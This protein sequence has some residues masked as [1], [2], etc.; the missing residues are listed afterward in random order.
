MSGELHL[1]L[2]SSTSDCNITQLNQTQQ[3]NILLA[4]GITAL[5]SVVSCIIGV[6]MVIALRLY[7]HFIYRLASYQVLGSLF[8]GTA[9]ALVLV[10]IDYDEEK[11]QYRV[12]C[13]ITAFLIEYSLWVKLIFTIWLTFHLFAYVVFYKNLK[14]L[15]YLYLFSPM[16]FPLLFVWIPFIDGS[17]GVSGAWCYIRSW[18]DNCATNKYDP[19]I[20]EQFVL[21][22]GP[23]TAALIVNIIIIIFMIVI[24][25]RRVRVDLDV[26]IQHS[27]ST[28]L[29]STAL[30]NKKVEVLKQLVPLLAYP[31]IYFTLLIFPLTNRIYMAKANSLDPPLI[32][33]QA[34]AQSSMGFFAGLALIL[35]IT[36]IQIKN[37]HRRAE[38]SLPPRTVS[39]VTPYSSGAMTNYSLLKET[40]VDDH[41][42]DF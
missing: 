26:R 9:M 25:L 28:S 38:E 20:I 10:L 5:F 7:K 17:Y 22:Y 11:L 31:I 16:L 2:N 6:S 18:N 30:R 19:G 33:A 37:R 34:V 4:N 39:G 41:R 1:W 27:E 21:Y 24:M 35:H 14:K 32:M 23:A 12:A 3:N 36:F 15:E 13:K 40:D 29:T 42:I 8:Q